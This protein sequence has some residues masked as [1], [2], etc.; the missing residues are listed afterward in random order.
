M[1]SALKKRRIRSDATA[2]RLCTI[3]FADLISYSK[4][5]AEDE[6]KTLRFMQNCFSLFEDYSA[7]HAGRVIKTTGDGVLALFDN[8]RNAVDFSIDVQSQI[9]SET[10]EYAFRI[11]INSGLVELTKDDVFG[12]AVNVAARLEPLAQPGGVCISR[13]VFVKLTDERQQKFFSMG[14]QRLYNLPG[15]Y[16]PFQMDV[17]PILPGK[18]DGRNVLHLSV[19]GGP[20][21]HANGVPHALPET[22]DARTLL[23]YL[24][25]APSNAEAVGRLSALLRPE[26][27]P[28]VARK[29]THLAL[30]SLQKAIGGALIIKDEVAS[31]NPGLVQT[32]IDRIVR[33]AARGKLDDILVMEGDWVQRIFSGLDEINSVVKSWLALVRSDVR[34]Q[35]VSVLEAEMQ[36]VDDDSDPAI[37]SI[38]NSILNMEPCHE[39]AAQRLMRSLTVTGNTAASMRVFDRLAQNLSTRYGL[40]PRPETRAAARGEILAG[41]SPRDP[42]APLRIQLRSFDGESKAARIRLASFRSEIVSGLSRFRSWSVVE[43]DQGDHDG[44]PK[45]GSDYVL[46]ASQTKDETHATLSL[47]AAESGRIVWSEDLDIG[48]EQMSKSRQQAVSR[49][50]AMFEMYVSTD[51]ST[52]AETSA[53]HAVVDDWLSGERLLTQWTKQAFEQGIARFED[54]IKRA[55]EFA[56]AHASLASALN[57]LHIVRP[58]LLRDPAMAKRALEASDIAVGLDPLDARNRLA[59]AWSSALKGNFDRAALNMDMAERL[60]PHSPRTLASCA[61]GFSFLGEHDRAARVLEHCLNCAPVLLDYQWCYAASIRFLGGD[62]AGA[63]LAAARS[64]DRI[65]DNPGWTAAALARSGQLAAARKAFDKLVHDVS[66]VW[67]GETSPNPEDVRDWFV[68]AYPIQHSAESRALEDALNAAMCGRG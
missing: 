52:M 38:S 56:P 19:I 65:I 27:S 7:H 24:A 54:L 64:D 14:P 1:V 16:E 20:K 18:G 12:H 61:M 42:L 59:L 48:A 60:N 45:A 6:A 58:G 5:V 39:G 50:A 51:R 37:R 8:P 2:P 30:S 55:P 25:M 3:L 11:G 33:H 17:G 63:L 68:S 13:D 4:H 32:D 62:D 31:L 34:E 35:L 36:K 40:E 26:A 29:A 67:D 53:H 28:N 21:L 57:V 15:A 49:I 41:P 66:A 46:S 43:G 22:Q 10:A 23:A 9:E 44:P 47:S